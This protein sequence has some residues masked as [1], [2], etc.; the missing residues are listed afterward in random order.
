V[1]TP[2][3]QRLKF[4][5]GGRLLAVVDKRG[6]GVTLGYDAG[7][8]LASVTDAGGRT[9]TVTVQGGL[10]AAVALPDGRTVH[11]GY[12]NNHLHTVQNPD[13][14]V[15]TY[16][17]D[18]ADRLSKYT[19]PLGHVQLQVAYDPANGRVSTQTDELGKVTAFRWDAGTQVSTVTDPDGV[20]TTDHYQGNVLLDSQNGNGD[21]LQYRYDSQ[22]NTQV[23]ADPLNRQYQAGFD[24]NGNTNSRTVLGANPAV[25]PVN[26]R[27]T[28]TSTF[29]AHNNLLSSTDERNQTSSYRRPTANTRRPASTTSPTRGSCTP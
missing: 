19:D 2:D 23:V 13:G 17:Y 29:D 14:N 1:T 8:Q 15:D 4:D 9:L 11:Y 18:A 6:K 28:A 5:A 22:L 27:A 16:D 21:T 25:D 20:V 12:A 3:Q 24:A 26:V 7:G 10:L